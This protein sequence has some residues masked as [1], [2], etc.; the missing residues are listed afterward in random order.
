MFQQG[1]EGINK[2][3]LDA[4]DNGIGISD[5]D[6]AKAEKLTDSMNRLG[7]SFQGL[8]TAFASTFADDMSK[9]F[10]WIAKTTKGLREWIEEN[11]SSVRVL[12]SVGSVVGGG[13]VAYK[14]SLAV[15]K[16]LLPVSAA[17]TTAEQA[18]AVAT[19][20]ATAATTA[21]TQAMVANTTATKANLAAKAQAIIKEAELAKASVAGKLASTG[22]TLGGLQSHKAAL[23]AELAMTE[24][25]RKRTAHQQLINSFKIHEASINQK[26]AAT[27]GQINAIQAK[28]AVLQNAELTATSK[29]A[30]A[31]R[32]LDATKAG[33]GFAE[34]SNGAEAMATSANKA[35]KA[36][37]G[38][39]A[40][41]RA[42]PGWGWAIA[43]VAALTAIVSWMSK[44]KDTTKNWTDDMQKFWDEIESRVKSAE[45]G[46]EVKKTTTQTDIQRLEV[47]QE[48]SGQKMTDDDFALAVKIVDELTKK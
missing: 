26:I 35:A 8:R 1:I 10:D 29:I 19:N 24:G 4:K 3:M 42:I 38:L 28:R 32:S 22:K 36:S 43:G 31:K 25:M 39:G 37:F 47:I 23:Q 12:T 30:R 9:S 6:A 45:K 44:A 17:A 46:V 48:R 20:S 11:K 14:I 7:R 41:I 34:F 16:A 2:A 27:E 15:K 40:A 33:S 18:N 5:E 21:Q 13:V